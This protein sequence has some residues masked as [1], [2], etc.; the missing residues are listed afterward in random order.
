MFNL[1]PLSLANMGREYVTAKFV[2]HRDFM[3]I[4]QVARGYDLRTLCPASLPNITFTY[5]QN[6]IRTSVWSAKL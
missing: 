1:H 5:T 4:R 3:V 2:Y 6:R